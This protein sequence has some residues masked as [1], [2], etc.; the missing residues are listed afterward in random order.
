MF[1]DLKRQIKLIDLIKFGNN[2]MSLINYLTKT[3]AMYGLVSCIAGCNPKAE[4]LA[5]SQAS[6]VAAQ[7][8]M[9]SKSEPNRNSY[10]NPVI[11]QITDPAVRKAM[12]A[13]DEV[14]TRD[15]ADDFCF[16]LEGKITGSDTIELRLKGEYAGKKDYER[17]IY[18][19]YIF[20]G[21][22]KKESKEN[23]Y[24][25]QCFGMKPQ[26]LKPPIKPGPIEQQI[27]VNTSQSARIIMHPNYLGEVLWKLIHTDISVN[28][29]N[30]KQEP[31]NVGFIIPPTTQ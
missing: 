20:C 1:A 19:K 16:T 17:E 25:G 4:E 31:I 3:V 7:R 21:A 23:E 26:R 14:K 8:D 27:T 18:V 29:N 11:D 2:K 6:N 12:D 9:H 30:P 10:S 24:K 28:P 5:Q 15:C 13:F 22:V